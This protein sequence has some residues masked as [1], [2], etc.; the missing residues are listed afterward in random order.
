LRA[1]DQFLQFAFDNVHLIPPRFQLGAARI[2]MRCI[3]RKTP[4]A[5]V[6]VM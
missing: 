3:Q 4:R 2:R 1:L 5:R 6:T